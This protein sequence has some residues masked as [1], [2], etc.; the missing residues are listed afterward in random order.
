MLTFSERIKLVE[1]YQKWIDSV[2]EE[3]KI[4]IE[5]GPEA[6]LIFLQSNEL[7]DVEEIR[8]YFKNNA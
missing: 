8:M 3:R 6:F 1:A 5:D 2:W 7:L 4:K